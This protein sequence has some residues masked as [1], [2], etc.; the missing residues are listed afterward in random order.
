MR[1]FSEIPER[2]NGPVLMVGKGPSF[3]P[4]KV[5]DF[6]SRGFLICGLNEAFAPCVVDFDFTVFHDWPITRFFKDS[7]RVRYFIASTKPIVEGANFFN[8]LDFSDE[9]K[10]RIYFYD[11]TRQLVFLNHPPIPIMISISESALKILAELGAREIHF[12]GVDGTMDHAPQFEKRATK[13]SLSRQFETFVRLKKEYGL[14]YHGLS[15]TYQ[16]FERQY[17]GS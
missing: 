4:E 2:I 1:H 9:Y 16:I 3:C 8:A 11:G 5:S 14:T 13:V 6:K 10:D 17:R 7:H 15:E 12:V